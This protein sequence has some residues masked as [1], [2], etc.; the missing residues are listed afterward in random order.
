MARIVQS[1]PCGKRISRFSA[2]ALT[3]CLSPERLR[4][5]SLSSIRGFFPIEIGSPVGM[6]IHCG[7]A[8]RCCAWPGMRRP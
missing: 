4:V 6:P 3:G 8:S 1:D 5:G 2:V 7:P